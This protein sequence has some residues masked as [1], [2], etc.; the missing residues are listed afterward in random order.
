MTDAAGSLAHLICVA[1]VTPASGAGQ[2]DVTAEAGPT[3][4]LGSPRFP[5]LSVT[6]PCFR[7]PCGVHSV[8]ACLCHRGRT[9][10]TASW[11]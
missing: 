4:T 9:W 6:T 5:E 1:R 11:L 3:E 10:L 8:A 7:L 2:R